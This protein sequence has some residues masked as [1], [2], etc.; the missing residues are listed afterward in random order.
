[1][2]ATGNPQVWNPCWLNGSQGGVGLP[3]LP[4]ESDTRAE[5]DTQRTVMPP[6][7]NIATFPFNDLRIRSSNATAV[8]T[9]REVS[10]TEVGRT[11]T[12]P[13]WHR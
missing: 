5:P 2:A 10:L 1:M 11:G 8:Q 9:T 7:R 13:Y 3:T 12:K 6:G 4:D